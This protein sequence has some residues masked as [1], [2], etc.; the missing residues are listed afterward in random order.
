[1]R[2]ARCTSASGRAVRILRFVV[3]ILML[4]APAGAKIHLRKAARGFQM[5]MESF[6][7]PPA[8]DLE[9]CEHLV[10]PNR[11]PMDVAAFQLN[12]TPGTHHFIVWDYLGQDQNPADF[13][14]GIEYSTACTGL[15][16]QDGSF[17]TANLFGMLSGRSDF[18]FPPGVAVRLPAHA[19]IYANLHYHNY[20]ETSV[21]TDSVFNFIPAKRGTVQHHAQAFTVGTLQF[22]IP[23]KGSASVTGEW[24][25]PV[26]LNLVSV[27]T[28]QHRR[29]TNILVHRIDGG[30]ADMGELVESPSWEHPTI[31][32]FPQAMRLSAGE[33]FRFTCSWQNP[34][35]HEVNFG[36]TTE[37]EMCF[38]AGYFYPDDDNATVTGP[39][40]LPQGAGLECF[41]PA[42]N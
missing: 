11:K 2:S 10:T 32:W 22:S 4:G 34:D 19:N 8:G 40:C 30:G 27:T 6:A 14:S 41:V 26:D 31:K 37:D 15:G 29:G 23:A 21:N 42:L 1:M 39:G 17:T 33:G 13:W 36:V 7:V 9:G 38:V 18:R 25:A 12:T 5:R 3:A 24:H 35:D 16:P 28:H 20:T